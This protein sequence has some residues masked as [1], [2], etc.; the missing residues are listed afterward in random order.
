L[1]KVGCLVQNRVC[2]WW[3]RCKKNN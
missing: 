1:P 3:I 2:D